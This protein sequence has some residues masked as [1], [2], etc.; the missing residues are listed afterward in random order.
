[1]QLKAIFLGTD[2]FQGTPMVIRMKAVKYLLFYILLWHLIIG[3]TKK[4]LPTMVQ[5]KLTK[6][7]NGNI[8]GQVGINQ[9][10]SQ[11]PSGVPYEYPEEVDLRIIVLTYARVKSLT[12]CLDSLQKIH[13]NRHSTAMEIWIDR[14]V[15][16]EIDIKTFEL[17]KRFFWKHGPVRVH[18][19][20][21]H[22]G[23]YGQWIDTWRPK[24]NTREIAV[25]IEDDVDVSPYFYWWLRAA[26][27][28]YE[29]RNDIGSI[30]LCAENVLISTGSNKGKKIKVV[31]METAYLYPVVISWG[32]SPVPVVW[33]QFQDWFYETKRKFPRYKPYTKGAALQTSWYRK[34]EFERREDSM[35]TMWFIHFSYQK[36]LYTLQPNILNVTGSGRYLAVHRLEKG[37]HSRGPKKEVNSTKRLLTMWKSEFIQF[38]NDPVKYGYNGAVEKRVG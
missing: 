25:F 29:H 17:A 4:S 10:I 5:L 24:E 34:F 20:T 27:K 3:L 33:R 26:H 6:K 32:T 11:K 23:I 22:V 1:M 9:I 12:K 21:K 19:W 37:L 31:N 35:W 28:F 18:V 15:N 14:N 38:P 2:S 16:D 8:I 36:H 30:G 7:I 13:I